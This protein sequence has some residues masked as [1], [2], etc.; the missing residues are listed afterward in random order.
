MVAIQMDC[1]T[2]AQVRMAAKPVASAQRRLQQVT[3]APGDTLTESRQ[4]DSSNKVQ[5]FDRGL[6]M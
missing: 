4:L 3:A 2:A 5:N 1:L 6:W